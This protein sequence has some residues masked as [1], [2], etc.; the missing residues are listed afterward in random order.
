MLG[1]GDDN[2]TP[3]PA[4]K[5]EKDRKWL[6]IAAVAGGGT[7]LVTILFYLKQSNAPAPSDPGPVTGPGGQTPTSS[8]FDSV[9]QAIANLGQQQ[10]TSTNAI[11]SA[12]APT[13]TPSTGTPNP[14]AA[15]DWWT[16]VISSARQGL[17]QNWPGVPEY[18]LNGGRLVPD[19][20][21]PWGS[22]VDVTS[23]AQSQQLISDSQ[24]GTFYQV[25]GGHFV[26]NL[27]L[28]N[29]P[30]AAQTP[31]DSLWAQLNWDTSGNNANPIALQPSPTTRGGP[32]IGYGQSV[33][34]LGDPV[35][36]SIGDSHAWWVPVQSGNQ[37]GFIQSTQIRGVSQSSN[38]YAAGQ[39]VSSLNQYIPPGQSSGHPI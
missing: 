38:P 10:Q 5:K 11:L 15:T 30:G 12:L 23:G 19:G 8:A 27:D 31:I 24:P 18:S 29:I 28:Q 21:I 32:S 16:N 4:G 1:I 34:I 9:G 14:P 3:A 13:S 33:H 37:T 7:L 25:A 26:Q 39:P 2:D 35:W 36:Q 22:S 20:Y 6:I 17:N